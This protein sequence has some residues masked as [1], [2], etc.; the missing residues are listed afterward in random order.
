MAEQENQSSNQGNGSTEEVNQFTSEQKPDPNVKPPNFEYVT[1][2]CEPKKDKKEAAIICARYSQDW[3]NNKEDVMVHLFNG[4]KVYK[5]KEM[6]IGTFGV[7]RPKKIKVKKEE[8]RKFN[9]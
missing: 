4:K 3:R 9:I 8:I 6:P 2:G 5:E 1:E 7:K